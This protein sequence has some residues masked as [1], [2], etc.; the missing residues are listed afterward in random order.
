MDR[1]GVNKFIQKLLAPI[2]G[3]IGIGKS[4]TS[5]TL[6]GMIIGLSF[7]GGLLIH[8]AKNGAMRRK[9]VFLSM[10]FIS[11][12]H[13]II[14][15]TILILLMGAD[16]LVVVILRLLYVLLIVFIIHKSTALF[17]NNNALN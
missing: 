5:L 14:E 7:G 15:D 17:L 4:A 10:C 16:F 8:E 6:I 1:S 11:M 2:L 3:M 12:Y 9:D 13:S